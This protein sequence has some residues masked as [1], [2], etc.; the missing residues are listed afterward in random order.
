MDY[1]EKMNK[2][3]KRFLDKYHE[4]GRTPE[5]AEEALAEVYS[6]KTWGRPKQLRKIEELLSSKDNIL[7]LDT[8]SHS[9]KIEKK[10]KKIEK[11]EEE[12]RKK[13]YND[14]GEV[15]KAGTGSA[16]HGNSKYEE[17]IARQAGM[18]CA[19]HGY[20][21]KQL[22]DFFEV[23]EQTINN[24]KKRFP[25]FFGSVK[26]GKKIADDMVVLS[27]YERATGAVVPD[28]KVFYNRE[29]GETVVVPLEKHY[30][31]DTRACEIWAHNRM[32]KDWRKDP[33]P[34]TG[35]DSGP[36]VIK[37]TVE[38]PAEE[39]IPEEFLKD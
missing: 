36:I 30:P 20:T 6:V 39:E 2:K 23:T 24:W 10:S 5:A 22:A 9:K 32:A 17:R 8:L 13:I 11:K 27:L 29:S 16:L 34:D 12:S 3:T 28:S 1:H 7:Y 33:K 26:N 4:K 15:F 18:L 35:D 19:R 37:M 38:R 21:D 25:D 31:P 14:S